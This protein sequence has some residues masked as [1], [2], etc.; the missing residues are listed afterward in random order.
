MANISKRQAALAIRVKTF[1]AQD[2]SMEKEGQ[3]VETTVGQ[4]DEPS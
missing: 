4:P 1:A 2:L 3:N